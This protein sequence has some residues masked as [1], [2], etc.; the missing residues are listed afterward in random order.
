[1]TGYKI[2]FTKSAEICDLLAEAHR[3]KFNQDGLYR[4]RHGMAS[5]CK[6]V[7]PEIYHDTDYYCCI[8]A[9]ETEHPYY[10]IIFA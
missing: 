3:S 10:E 8:L 9:Y 5:L 6:D 7:I 2:F 4:I 1:M